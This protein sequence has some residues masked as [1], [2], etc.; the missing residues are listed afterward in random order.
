MNDFIFGPAPNTSLERN[1][2]GFFL[3][4]RAPIR[5][6]HLN[7]SLY[8]ILQ[9]VW[10]GCSVSDL[11]ARHPEI[12]KAQLL[13]ILLSLT[14]RGY[15]ELKQSADLQEFPLVSIVIPVRNPSRD[16]IE[17]LESLIRL[18]YPQDRLEIIV[19][20]DGN[21]DIG[22]DLSAF[23]VKRLSLAESQGPGTARNIG[24]RQATGEILAFLD[25]DCIADKNWLRD[26]LPFFTIEGIGAVGGFV[27][28]YYRRSLLDRY[29]EVSSSLN[30]GSRLLLEGDTE[31]TLY[32][33]TCNMLI[34]R[35]VF[36]SSGGF[37][38][39]WRLGED[40]DLCWKMRKWGYSL[41]YLPAG[42]VAHKHR[43]RLGQMLRRR[44][45]Y[46]SSEAALYRTHPEK[47]KRFLI[48]LWAGLSF[49][50][51]ALAIV[52][53][54]PYPLLLLIPLLAFDLI[55]KSQALNRFRIHFPFGRV[56]LSTLRSHFSFYYFTSFHLV[57]YYLVLLL[58]VGF[59]FHPIWYICAFMVLLISAVD[60]AV[61]KPRLWYPVYLF[62]YL[63][64]HLAYQVGVFRGCL[65]LR[66]FGS[67]IP[68]FTHR[69]ASNV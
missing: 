47:K 65:K 30:L 11:A 34:K 23:P 8:N 45:D 57:R 69:L 60:Y 6:I 22:L 10:D 5:T 35:Q 66:Y 42:R 53:H 41:L 32:V 38:D 48:P 55:Q 28:G 46:G 68:A 51:V 12:K 16:L 9:E 39:G 67:Y 27:D 31:S 49:L 37:N 50:S 18:D 2:Q 58:A 15:F 24:A 62:Y 13:R 44:S 3:V 25:A 20:E 63:A 56:A 21:S 19:V 7:Q 17:C 26:I 40:V 61:K 4:S 64:E 36:L 1:S 59:A 54:H 33:P 52:L 14:Y 29:E 43:N